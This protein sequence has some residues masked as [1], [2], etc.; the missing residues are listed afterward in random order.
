MLLGKVVDECDSS[1][2]DNP[3]NWKGGGRVKKG[4]V[5]YDVSP[6]SLRGPYTTAKGGGC[7]STYK[8]FWNEY[9][10]WGNGWSANDWGKALRDQ[11]DDCALFSHTW[12]FEYGTGSDGREW[13]AKFQTGIW[14]KGC[15]GNAIKEAGGTNACNG[16]G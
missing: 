2:V 1:P 11:V 7:D 14:Q 16:S 4:E 13:T 12:S 8:V 10:V 6:V 3:A 9:V 5:T 15:V